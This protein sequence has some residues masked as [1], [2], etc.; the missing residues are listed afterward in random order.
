MPS[1]YSSFFQT[2]HDETQLVGKLGR[3]TH[4]SVLRAP[5]WQSEFL[6]PLKQGAFLDFAVIWDEDH[7]DRVIGVIEDLYFSA[8]LSPVRFSGERKG[9][10]SVLLDEKNVAWDADNFAHYRQRVDDISRH[11]CDPWPAAV[12]FTYTRSPSLM[13]PSIIH[14]EHECV[15]LYLKN[16]DMLWELGI[17]SRRES[18]RRTEAEISCERANGRD[19]GGSP[20]DAQGTVEEKL[21]DVIHF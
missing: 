19:D 13:Q 20:A 18:L 1:S 7:D 2:L 10:L 5:I 3:G 21:D 11:Q 15:T 9:T 14:A 17:K 4:Y 12:E 8:L 16:I 6:K